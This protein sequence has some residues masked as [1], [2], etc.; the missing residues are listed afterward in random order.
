MSSAQTILSSDR[1]G[2]PERGSVDRRCKL[3]DDVPPEYNHIRNVV[4]RAT[5]MPSRFPGMDPYLEHPG[6][7]PDF[8]AEF[9]RV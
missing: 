8:H 5:K 6:V 4:E 3:D 2:L 7:W 1:C 9:I